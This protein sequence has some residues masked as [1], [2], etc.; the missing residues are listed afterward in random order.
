MNSKERFI[1]A[2]HRQPVDRVPLFDFLF[3]QP[4]Y[5][6]LIGTTP[7]SFNAIDAMK[8]T[9]V[10]NL[11]G[12]WIPY[13]AFA[14]W[15]PTKLTDTRY[16][17]EWGTTFEQCSASWPIDPPVDYPIK[18]KEDLLA[19]IPPDANLEGRLA[20]IN[21]AIQINS[22]S[23]NPVA[24]CGGVAGPLTTAWMLAGYENI[25]MWLYDDPEILVEIAD[26]AVD[27]SIDAASQMSIAGVDALFLSEDL[28]SSTGGLMSPKHFKEIFKPALAKLIS[29]I[30]NKG[31]LVLVHSCGRIYDF[32]DDL[33][34]LK[35]DA[36]HPLQRTAGMD[37]SDVKTKYGDKLCIIGNID[38]SRT[39]PYGS[40]EDVENEVKEAI[41]TASK[42]WGYILASDHSLH[43][44]IPIVNIKAM[45]DAGR[46]YG[47][48]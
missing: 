19:Y 20:E 23:S 33:V 10:L 43:D 1:K 11:D 12:V 13:G 6:E 40:P 18:S 28:G 47:K 24:V 15:T 9:E 35:I 34:E 21:T 42:N 16:I 45:F 48:Y 46:K 4:L 39:L 25:C 38:S 36:I 26:I 41:E 14:G 44:G 31:L 2:V 37:L 32:L 30:K 7:E 22:K 8:L 27:Y 5:T 29:H 3:Q 17:D